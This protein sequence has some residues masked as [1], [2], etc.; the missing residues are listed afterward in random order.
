LGFELPFSVFYLCP[1]NMEPPEELPVESPET[2]PDIPTEIGPKEVPEDFPR[3]DGMTLHGLVSEADRSKENVNNIKFLLRLATDYAEKK[4]LRAKSLFWF[5]RG[6]QS[7]DRIASITRDKIIETGDK[8]ITE[9]REGTTNDEVNDKAENVR[10]LRQKNK[11]TWKEYNFQKDKNRNQLD[12]GIDEMKLFTAE[13]GRATDEHEAWVDDFNEYEER[14]HARLREGHESRYEL[15]PIDG[16]D[17]T[18]FEKPLEDQVKQED[19][20]EPV[21]ATLTEVQQS[22]K[23]LPHVEQSDAAGEAEI[24]KTVES[25]DN[26]YLPPE[27]LHDERVPKLLEEWKSL[28]Q[29]V[30]QFANEDKLFQRFKPST[31]QSTPL[32]GFRDIHKRPKDSTTTNLDNSILT[33]GK[34]LSLNRAVVS[35][36][37]IA[38]D[39]T[40]SKEPLDH[41]QVVT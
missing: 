40:I 33:M 36:S 28:K 31:S 19:N 15:Q 27:T 23:I 9:F 12:R 1:W 4:A 35:S 26:I 32:D 25:T 5:S 7:K 18:S 29:G 3:L 39:P 17:E 8:A 14:R 20:E 21:D 24:Q 30:Q 6:R 38:E 34:S 2:I 41:P 22:R 13:V 37:A 11:E 16:H 10:E